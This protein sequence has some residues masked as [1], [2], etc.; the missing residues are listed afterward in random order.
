[1]D[2]AINEEKKC[3]M[4]GLTS[5]NP[6]IFPYPQLS[7]LTSNMAEIFRDTLKFSQHSSTYNNILALAATGVENKRGGGFEHDMHG[8]HAIKM[9]GRTYHFLKE[10]T[11]SSTDPSCGLSY[12]I[13]DAQAALLAHKNNIPGAVTGEIDNR[14]LQNV[15]QELSQ[16]NYLCQ[17]LRDIGYFCETASTSPNL[18]AEIN[19]SM[20]YFEVAHITSDSLTGNR[21]LRIALKNR[22]GTTTISLT[23]GLMEPLSYPIFFNRGEKGWDKD[24]RKEVGF[25]EYLATRLLQPEYLENGSPFLIQS[26]NDPTKLLHVNRFQAAARARQVY[27]VDMVSRAIDFRLNWHSNNQDTIFSG[28]HPTQYNADLHV[29]EVIPEKDRTTFLPSSFN[30]GRRNLK[31]RASNALTIVSELERPTAFITLTG[32]PNWPEVQSQLLPGQTAFDRDDIM[33]MAFK[34]RLGYIL[35]NIKSGKYFG[36]HKVVYIIHVIEFQHR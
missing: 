13:F 15:Y 32:N 25:M 19:A 2:N 20:T 24:I 10:A 1:L 33:C 18:I 17:E 12:F 34:A 28:E 23:D 7:P 8:P 5:Y 4:C 11:S 22:P 21:C 26:K 31:M 9:N 16:I 6:D 27:L 29:S 14:I 35:K 36:P 30:G 3:C